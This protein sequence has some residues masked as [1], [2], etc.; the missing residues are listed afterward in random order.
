MSLSG[1][2]VT[3]LPN[4]QQ[5]LLSLLPQIQ[6]I[7][8]HRQKR[9]LKGAQQEY[10]IADASKGKKQIQTIPKSEGNQ[11]EAKT[12]VKEGPGGSPLRQAKK[13]KPNTLDSDGLK[14]EG[15]NSAEKERGEHKKSKKSQGSESLDEP[16][17]NSWAAKSEA[18]P[19]KIAPPPSSKQKVKG[20]SI[21]KSAS[22][23]AKA[24][25]GKLGGVQTEEVQQ[26]SGKVR[27]KRKKGLKQAKVSR[28]AE[29]GFLSDL[30]AGR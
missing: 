29:P 13:R 22:K 14:Q 23:S 30:I 26:V 8:G 20:D 9:T 12:E 3:A 11:I 16:A 17:G 4:F 2:P 1:C 7:D 5:K 28:K 24:A 19:L 6:I 25:A 10:E 27:D 15:A 21:A 18:A